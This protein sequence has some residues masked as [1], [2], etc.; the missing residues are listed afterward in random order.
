MQIAIKVMNQLVRLADDVEPG[1]YIT[2]GAQQPTP[3]LRVLLD[4]ILARIPQ[5]WHGNEL[6]TWVTCRLALP[7]DRQIVWSVHG[8]AQPTGW[9]EPEP[10]LFFDY[11]LAAGHVLGEIVQQAMRTA[12]D[13]LAAKREAA[14]KA[15]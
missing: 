2:V 7:D 14:R 9:T 15:S 8:I 12:A 3:A 5:A 10:G 6:T 13:E 4:A 1:G 11:E